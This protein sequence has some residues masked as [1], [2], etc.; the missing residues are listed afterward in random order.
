[1]TKYEHRQRTDQYPSETGS[2]TVAGSRLVKMRTGDSFF[3]PNDEDAPE[4]EAW[5]SYST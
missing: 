4:N 3:S 5:F 1:M 2:T